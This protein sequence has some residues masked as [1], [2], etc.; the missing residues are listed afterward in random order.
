MA[1][2]IKG[3]YN[4]D[5]DY[6]KLVVLGRLSDEVISGL[7]AFGD[8]SF[9][10]LMVMLTGEDNKYNILPE[11]FEKLPQLTMKN[12]KE[13]RSVIN[14]IVDKPSSVL[15]FNWISYTQKSYRQKD[16]PMTN[17]KV[18]EFVDTLPY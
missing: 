1:L 12:T 3:T 13:F 14:G 16:V 5:T 17:I 7:G 18:P 8:F 2:F 10:K 4:P 9:N 15:L 11:D 6:A